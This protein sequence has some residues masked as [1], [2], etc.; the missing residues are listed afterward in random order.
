MNCGLYTCTTTGCKTTCSG[1]AD[2]ASGAFC[3]TATN[4]CAS[5]GG[6]GAGCSAD[7]QCAAGRCVD[8]VCCNTKDKDCPTCQS[9]NVT[10]SAGT[11]TFVGTGVAEP[12]GSCGATPGKCGNTGTCAADQTCA[13]APPTTMCGDPSCKGGSQTPAAFCD[14]AGNCSMPAAQ[15]CDQYVCGPTACKTVCATDMDCIAGDYCDMTQMCQPKKA[16]GAAC[17]STGECAAGICGAA[18]VCC[19]TTDATCMPM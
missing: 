11:C 16:P 3:D 2:C 1:P 7:N 6:L 4:H 17:T 14:G 15:S 19:D 8:G 10:G 13:K 9:C 12:H 5:A 18:G